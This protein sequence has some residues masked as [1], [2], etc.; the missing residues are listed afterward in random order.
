MSLHWLHGNIVVVWCTTRCCSHYAIT[1]RLPVP[2]RQS[3]SVW[4]RRWT[5]CELNNIQSQCTLVRCGGDTAADS[6]HCVTC[7][8]YW[9]DLS[10]VS[11]ASRVSPAWELLFLY[12][13]TLHSTQFNTFVM[14][15]SRKRTTIANN[16]NTWLSISSYV[17][18]DDNDNR[19][20]SLS[21]SWRLLLTT[22]TLVASDDW[23]HYL[24]QTL[25]SKTIKNGDFEA[26]RKKWN[27]EKAFDKEKKRENREWLL[28]GAVQVWTA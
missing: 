26:A 9:V 8:S 7:V 2:P 24:E 27:K 23:E 5:W 14:S 25:Q 22:M 21:S 17:R 10:R 20:R 18:D 15:L 1:V 3:V 6:G 12:S 19:L 13:T 4:P 16:N 28:L 11:A